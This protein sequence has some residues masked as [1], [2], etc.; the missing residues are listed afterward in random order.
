M[1]LHVLLIIVLATCSTQG[2]TISNNGDGNIYKLKVVQDVT[3]EKSNVNYN[4]LQ[5]LLVARHPQYPLK[6]SLIQF[7][8][9]PASCPLN[10]IRWAK[11]YLYF[12]YAHKASWQ[13]VSQAPYLTHTIHIHQ[14]KQSWVETQATSILRKNGKTW[15]KEYLDLG[16]DAEYKPV[17]PATTI[18]TSRPRGFVEFDITGAIRS[19]KQGFYNYGLLLKVV[20]EQSNGRDLRFF[21]KESADSS[22]HAF[23]NVM[24]NY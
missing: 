16:K 5:Y 22:K 1:A 18:Y 6:R 9:L 20:N 4:Y 7:E 14:V 11:M 10:K 17:C 15:F 21:S 12:A 19:W 8:N 2:L 23:V 3:L 13:S 24:C